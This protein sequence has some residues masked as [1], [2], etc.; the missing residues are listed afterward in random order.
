[1][2]KST[3][4][5]LCT[6]LF[7][8][9]AAANAYAGKVI[10]MMG[11]PCSLPLAEKL[12]A[13]YSA[14]DKTFKVEVA[15]VG[16]MMGVYRAANNEADI[17]VSTQNGLDSNLP[18]GASNTVIA[19]APIVL[20]VN[21]ENRVNN[22]TYKQ[23]QDIYDGKIRN[24]K[25]VGGD[26]VEIENV[27]LEPCVRYTMSKKVISYDKEISKLSPGKKVNPVT[28]TNVMVEQSI[29]AIGQ[30]LYGYETP[31]V[32]ILSI[33][34]ILPGEETVPDKYTF[35]EEYN[36]VT[37]KNPS[38]SIKKFI[39]FARSDEGKKIIRSMKHIP[40]N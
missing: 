3:I 2:Q 16:C 12:V 1:M 18:R 37:K 29:G 5:I 39:E 38:A 32:K 9:S 4:N 14:K 26:D 27:M 30:Q 21:R 17:G 23:L 33:D 6:L 11:D 28:H 10:T 19:K 7:T 13:A 22:L 8:I 25:E 15:T 20:V 24:W 35:F 31:D 34:G 40:V 36:V